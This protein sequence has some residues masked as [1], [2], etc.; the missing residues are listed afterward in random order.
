MTG[1]AEQHVATFHADGTWTCSCGEREHV[2][3]QADEP[4]DVDDELGEL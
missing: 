1:G 4:D 2:E 3:H